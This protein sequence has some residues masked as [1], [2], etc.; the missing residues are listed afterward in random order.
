[1]KTAQDMKIELDS[2]KKTLTE[3]KLKIDNLESQP[4]AS[5]ARLI[6]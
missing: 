2:P 6:N 4:K 1:M 3:I 5:K